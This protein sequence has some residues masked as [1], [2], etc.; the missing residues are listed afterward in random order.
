[1]YGCFTASVYFG[2][3]ELFENLVLDTKA[4]DDQNI[5][6]FTIQLIRN[7]VVQPGYGVCVNL[8]KKTG[9]LFIKYKLQLLLY[10]LYYNYLQ[11]HGR[12]PADFPDIQLR[13]VTEAENNELVFRYANEE[14]M[15]S[16]KEIIELFINYCDKHDTNIGFYT[17]VQTEDAAYNRGTTTYDFE[18]TLEIIGNEKVLY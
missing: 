13:P 9:E 6:I 16:Q 11:Y 8:N 15:K 10:T 3:L 18:T 5:E 14:C 1:M 4:F 7:T 17:G 12:L 2:F